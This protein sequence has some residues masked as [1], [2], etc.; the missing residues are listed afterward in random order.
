M[1]LFSVSRGMGRDSLAHG[2]LFDAL[3]E[4]AADDPVDVDARGVDL[5][6]VQLA[7]F[8]DFLDFDHGDLAGGR[9]QRVEVL[10]GV[11][12]DDIAEVVGF[13]AFDDGE[14]AGDGLFHQV[15]TAVEFTGFLAVGDRG[16][17][18]GG[19]EEGWDAG[20]TG[21]HFLGQGA[22]GGQYHFDFTA[23]QLFFEEGVFT[24]I[25]GDHLADLPVFQQ[26]AE[27]KAVDAA[28]VGNHGQVA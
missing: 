27:A 10:G 1:F 9:G 11:A 13:P 28:V 8:D 15:R 14:V 26:H 19:R 20:A 25:G 5:R 2:A 3:L 12:I 23:E 6:R 18:P 16:A 21:A 4:R 17:D 7:G 22:L 24:D